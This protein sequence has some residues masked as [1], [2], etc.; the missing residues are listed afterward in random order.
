M[1]NRKQPASIRHAY[2]SL[3]V[4]RFYRE[5][6]K[7]YRNPHEP[8]IRACLNHAAREWKL[9]LSHALD[10]AAGSGE[11]TLALRELGAGHIDA[12]DPFTFDAYH[13]RTGAAA[14]RESFEQ[15]ASGAI[16]DRRYSL[17][18]CS[19]AMHLVERS[20]LPGL[21]GALRCITDSLL[22]LTPHKRPEIREDWGWKLTQETVIQRVRMRLYQSLT[23]TG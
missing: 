11:V 10:L 4:A 7:A 1:L 18:V 21:C 14:T 12:M 22:I 9:D 8:Q 15:I 16:S 20:R 23:F 3:G 17:V 13:H 2:E 6:G 5:K 19:F